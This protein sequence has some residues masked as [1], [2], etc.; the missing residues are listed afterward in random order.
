MPGTFSFSPVAGTVLPAGTFEMV[1]S[2][3]AGTATPA[4]S[5]QGFGDIARPGSN[6]LVNAGFV[7]ANQSSPLSYTISING[8]E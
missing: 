5:M 2:S 4:S 7:N 1:D 6:P 3:S 8:Q